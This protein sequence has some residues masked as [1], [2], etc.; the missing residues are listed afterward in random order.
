M[1]TNDDSDN[2]RQSSQNEKIIG[3]RVSTTIVVLTNFTR[4][5]QFTI[6][7]RHWPNKIKI[8]SV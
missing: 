8:I 1:F 6:A 7:N 2:K 4:K 5:V 3:L